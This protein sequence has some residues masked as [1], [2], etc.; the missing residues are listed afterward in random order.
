MCCVVNWW[1]KCQYVWLVIDS[2]LCRRGSIL[3]KS[4]SFLILSLSKGLSLCF[5]CS[6]QHVK[7]RM[8]IGFLWLTVCY[9]ITMLNNTHIHMS[10]LFW[11]S[12]AIVVSIPLISI[13]GLSCI[14]IYTVITKINRCFKRITLSDLPIW[15]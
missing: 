4:C 15:E 8:L 11:P 7:Y 10:C 1:Q 13:A 14:Y 12:P 3:G 2:H 6:D 9:W 5:M